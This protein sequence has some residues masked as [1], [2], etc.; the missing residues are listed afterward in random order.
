MA[1]PLTRV[2]R[3]P[4]L[5]VL[6]PPSLRQPASPRRPS[7]QL[8]L[9]C[10]YDSIPA[11]RG[12]SRLLGLTCARPGGRLPG[13]PAAS[14]GLC[15]IP[16]AAKITAGQRAHSRH[17]SLPSESAN[18]PGSREQ[19]PPRGV[20]YVSRRDPAERVSLVVWIP[21]RPALSQPCGK[22]GQATLTFPGNTNHPCL[23]GSPARTWPGR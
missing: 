19:G 22:P 9:A 10:K 23:R 15:T 4:P 16:Q 1:S 5:L 14:I 17:V 18:G 13:S 7:C 12:A 20:V 3:V 11:S 6:L 2:S 21:T 8:A